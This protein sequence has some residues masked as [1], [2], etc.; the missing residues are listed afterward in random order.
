MI[1]FILTVEETSPGVVK[2]DFIGNGQATPVER[3]YAEMLRGAIREAMD[4]VGALGYSW[5]KQDSIPPGPS[6]TP[7]HS[8][9][10]GD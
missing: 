2:V 5:Q 9:S 10:P 6:S 4:K 8:A 1:Q 7:P 3:D